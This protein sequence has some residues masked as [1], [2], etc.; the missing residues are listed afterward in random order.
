MRR[1]FVLCALAM[2]SWPIA[3]G[4]QKYTDSDGR[5]RVA[6]AKQPFRPNGQSPGPTTMA[7]GGIQRILD[8][9]GAVVRVAEA[10]LT[11]EEDTGARG[12]EARIRMLRDEH[13]GEE[14]HV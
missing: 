8:G 5:L 6:L 14:E 7:E 12:T 2:L 4:A 3:A 10:G 11:P 13:I 1:L 9:M